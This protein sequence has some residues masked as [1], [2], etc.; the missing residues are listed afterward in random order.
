M[1]DALTKG[2]VNP[3]AAKSPTPPH[4]PGARCRPL[5][6]QAP[7]RPPACLPAL[8]AASFMRAFRIHPEPSPIW[9][10]IFARPMPPPV[11]SQ[12]A[13]GPVLLVLDSYQRG[14]RTGQTGQE[15]RLRAG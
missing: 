5:A 1:I 2:K 11:T 12:C 14:G 6:A 7:V 10:R 9:R 8:P 3:A 4:P 13:A 15:A